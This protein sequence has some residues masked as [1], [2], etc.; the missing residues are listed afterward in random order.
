MKI[1][2]VLILF[3]FHKVRLKDLVLPRVGFIKV[4][5][6]HKV[7]LKARPTPCLQIRCS[8]SIP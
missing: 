4:F 5:Q 8:V 1:L 7:R 2:K 3:Q 6:F